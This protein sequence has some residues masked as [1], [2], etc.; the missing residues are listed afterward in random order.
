MTLSFTDTH[1][2]SCLL[3][4]IAFPAQTFRYYMSVGFVSYGGHNWFACGDVQGQ[5]LAVSAF[6]DGMDVLPNNDITLSWGDGTIHG[7]TL[8]GAHEL[9]VVKIYEAQ[10]D[11]ST[12]ALTVDS[13]YRQYYIQEVG[14][15]IAGESINFVLGKGIQKHDTGVYSSAYRDTLHTDNDAAFDYISGVQSV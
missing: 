12:Y 3:V 9:A 1:Y 5:V 2:E 11:L 10:R 13:A 14:E 7:Y 6:E 4:E 8:S 15:A